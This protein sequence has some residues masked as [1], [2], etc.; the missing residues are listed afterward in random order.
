ML[1]LVF[2]H[3][4]MLVLVSWPLTH[5]KEL[6]KLGELCGWDVRRRSI[7]WGSAYPSLASYWPS[8]VWSVMVLV[9]D[10]PRLNNY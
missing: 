4:R 6:G 3:Y 1:T 8:V 10:E 9:A 5:R 7:G 2:Y